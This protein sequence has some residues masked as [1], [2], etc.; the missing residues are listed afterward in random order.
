MQET[1]LA[2]N[3]YCPWNKEVLLFDCIIVVLTGEYYYLV[4]L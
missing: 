1:Y 4:V 3:R 2:S